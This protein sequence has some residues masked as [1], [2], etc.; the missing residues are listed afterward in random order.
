MPRVGV[1]TVLSTTW[2]IAHV[3]VVGQLVGIAQSSLHA[4]S[5]VSMVKQRQATTTISAKLFIPEIVDV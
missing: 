1:R 2:P 3:V 5:V 4:A